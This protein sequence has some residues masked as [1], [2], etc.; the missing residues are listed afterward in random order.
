M[1]N[2]NGC[3]NFLF[4]YNQFLLLTKPTQLFKKSCSFSPFLKNDLFSNFSNLFA[5]HARNLTREHAV[6]TTCKRS[7]NSHS[8]S[9]LIK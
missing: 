6:C 3:K 5:Q 4:L 7:N 2:K 9:K 1:E 8:H